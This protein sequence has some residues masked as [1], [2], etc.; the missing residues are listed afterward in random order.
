MESNVCEGE[1]FLKKYAGILLSAAIL[2]GMCG[3]DPNSRNSAEADMTG[4]ETVLY[5]E[6]ASGTEGTAV[7][8]AETASEK[9][10]EPETAAD[11]ETITE[12]A[13]E[14]EASEPE[15]LPG[16]EMLISFLSYLQCGSGYWTSDDVIY[17][18]LFGK[19]DFMND[20]K[21]DSYS[22]EHKGDGIYH[23]TLTCSESNCEMFP[24]G[25]SYWYVNTG[26]SGRFKEMFAFYPAGRESKSIFSEDMVKVDEPLY[27]AICA[28][29]NFSLYT[30]VYEADEEWFVT[31]EHLYPHGF[32]DAYN[33]YRK[34]NDHGGVPFEELII[35]TKKLYNVTIP[36]IAFDDLRGKD[37]NAVDYLGEETANEIIC[38][39]HGGSWLY[40]A[41]AGYEETDSDIKVRLD[42]YG[43]EIYF[44][45]VIESE[46]TFSK[47]D[48]GTITLQKVEKIFDR[49]YEPASGTI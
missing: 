24:D 42:Y 34:A 9:V 14:T 40:E 12:T 1:F 21:L 45:P 28:A 25:A 29:Y 26:F 3:C 32:L 8:E 19:Y 23:V 16:E 43:D 5:V 22:Y 11:S 36:E 35:S 17:S 38:Y 47:N 18:D 30:S 6:E 31:Y 20:F 49:G 4:S 33:P 10:S 46:Y 7:T 15:Y 48:D 41:F 13:T 39:G 37:T 44:F 2:C 27:T